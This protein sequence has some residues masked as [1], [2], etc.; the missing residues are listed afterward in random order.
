MK[1][2][3]TFLKSKYSREETIKKIM[4]TDVDYI[5]VDMMDGKFVPRTVLTIEEAKSCLSNSIKP[6]EIH[7]MVEH[8]N[9]YINELAN[10]NVSYLTIHAEIDD[11]IDYLISL[12]HSYGINAGLALNPETKVEAI[13]DYLD[14][15]DYVLIMGVKPGYG[16]QALIPETINKISE[17]KDL[18]ERYNYHYK[19]ALD[20]GVN[21]TNRHLLNDLDIVIAGS[22]ICE[23]DNYQDAIN[24][25]K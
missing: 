2:S 23:S 14:Q 21:N 1:T 24:T 22:Y 15:I 18:R 4:E 6:L 13:N 25:L 17:L 16:G 8:P 10:L 11:D 12:I 9:N 20:G 7:L 19:I 5:H 3:V